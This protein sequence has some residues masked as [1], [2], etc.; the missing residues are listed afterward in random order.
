MDSSECFWVDD[1]LPNL[2]FKTLRDR[3]NLI[4]LFKIHLNLNLI[5]N[6]FERLNDCCHLVMIL[7]HFFNESINYYLN[8]LRSILDCIAQLKYLVFIFPYYQK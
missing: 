8:N 3:F 5:S 7:N 4:N 1:V 6:G 2:V